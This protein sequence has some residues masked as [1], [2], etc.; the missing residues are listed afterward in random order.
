MNTK[1]FLSP[2][3]L[4]TCKESSKQKGKR[5]TKNNKRENLPYF[6]YPKV[7]EKFSEFNV[8]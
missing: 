6:V 8:G 4:T 1:K 2:I 5:A 3:I 7:D